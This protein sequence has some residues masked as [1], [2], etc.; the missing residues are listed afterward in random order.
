MS[1]PKTQPLQVQL[2]D[3]WKRVADELP[4]ADLT[5]LGHNPKWGEPVWLCFLD[6]DVWREE[7]G[8]R[9]LGGNAPTHWMHVPEPPTK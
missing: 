9:L 3:Q 8:L 1:T 4:D 6:G 2:C 7:D 5:V